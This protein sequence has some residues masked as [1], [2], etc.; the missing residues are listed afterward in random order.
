MKTLALME[1]LTAA[2]EED[3]AQQLKQHKRQKLFHLYEQ[4]LAQPD[5]EKE[6]LFEILFKDNYTQKKDYKLRNE[7]RLL[8]REIEAFWI[9]QQREV[10]LRKDSFRQQRAYFE[11]LMKRGALKLLDSE[12]QEALEQAEQMAHFQQLSFLWKLRASLDFRLRENKLA[13]LEDIR[14]HLE[15]ARHYQYWQGV[16]DYLINRGREAYIL[17]NQQGYTRKFSTGLTDLPFR[18]S[19]LKEH[20]LFEYLECIAQA[21]LVKGVEKLR[22]LERTLELWEEISDIRPHFAGSA[23]QTEAIIATEYSIQRYFEKSHQA[24]QKVLPPWNQLQVVH[25]PIIYNYVVNLLYMEKLDLVE[26]CFAAVK[27]ILE[28]SHRHYTRFCYMRC[29]LY[30]FQGKNKAGLDLLI[31]DSLRQHADFD[32]YYARLLF[33]LLYFQMD[34]WESCEREL[35]NMRQRM[36]YKKKELNNLFELYANALT[37]LLKRKIEPQTAEER[38]IWGQRIICELEEALEQE[39]E[40]DLLFRKWICAYINNQKVCVK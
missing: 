18:E 36:R 37:E 13:S 8:N 10:Q 12:W 7:L 34:D 26:E 29:W 28:P 39:K 27:K 38:A 19:V 1:Q 24:F 40:A 30:L 16:E 17:A 23:R 15:K 35:T 3:L 20:P 11:L 4:L 22:Y 14:V 25:L 9:Q 21:Y 2:E 31:T 32:N 33:A 6:V 5:I